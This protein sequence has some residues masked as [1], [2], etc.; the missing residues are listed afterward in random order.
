VKIW[1]GYGSE[2]SANLVI[3]GHFET[4]ENAGAAAE[5]L[6]SV[7]QVARED[8]EAGRIVAG[9]V[10]SQYSEEMLDYLSRS[11]L[12][13]SYADTEA[14]IYDFS[15]KVE[16]KDLVITTEEL[17]INVFLTVMVRKGAQI[18]VFSAHDHPGRYGRQTAE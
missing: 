12:S 8:E 1:R 16:G 14:L 2:H 11:N 4:A 3:I 17:N 18:E 5:L 13:L 10:P 15:T 9:E 6:K 7:T